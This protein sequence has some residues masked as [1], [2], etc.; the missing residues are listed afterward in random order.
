MTRIN[1]INADFLCLICVYPIYPGAPVLYWTDEA[2][3]AAR[4]L[5]NFLQLPYLRTCSAED[6]GALYLAKAQG[7]VEPATCPL[8]KSNLYGYGANSHDFLWLASWSVLSGLDTVF[9]AFLSYPFR[10]P[11]IIL[12]FPDKTA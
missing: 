11:F 7:I 1:R 3:R 2:F 8:C 9:K 10:R 4:R 12:S 5:N 6:N